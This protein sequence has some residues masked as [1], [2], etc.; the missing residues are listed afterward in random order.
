MKLIKR[1]AL[2]EGKSV[3]IGF[4]EIISESLSKL[5]ENTFSEAGFKK[6]IAGLH[7][8]LKHSSPTSPVTLNKGIAA[9]NQRQVQPGI[10]EKLADNSF[11]KGDGNTYFQGSS[12]DLARA[13]APITVFSHQIDQPGTYVLSHVDIRDADGM[14]D[15]ISD[16][17]EAIHKNKV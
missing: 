8:T 2:L 3:K 15:R 7:S 9:V 17:L 14:H 16:A 11:G 10:I 1:L 12:D 5:K 13:L 4:S 6:A